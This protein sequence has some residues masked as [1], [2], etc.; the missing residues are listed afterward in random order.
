MEIYN[1]C[2]CDLLVASTPELELRED[3]EGNSHV[4]GVRRVTITAAGEV[5]KLLKEGNRRR[6]QEATLANQ[7]SSRSHAVLEVQVE[8]QSSIPGTKTTVQTGR[9]FM[10][11]LA[12]SERVRTARQWQ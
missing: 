2:L 7:A 9:L 5:F 1:E 11:D 6:T 10:I 12:G 3:H 4:C 8:K